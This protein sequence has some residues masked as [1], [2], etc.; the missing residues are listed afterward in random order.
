MNIF[1]IR[2][3]ITVEADSAEEI[4]EKSVALAQTIAAENSFDTIVSVVVS[5]TEDIRAFYPARAIREASVLDG[6][7]FSCKEP[8]IAGALPLCIRLL[9]TVTSNDDAATAH[10]VYLGKARALRKDLAE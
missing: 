3:A 10:H 1:A 8:E 6:P 9:V 2:G 4:I 7:I 5:T